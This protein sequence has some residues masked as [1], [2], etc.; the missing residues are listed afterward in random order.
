MFYF[1]I[2]VKKLGGKSVERIPIM[3]IREYEKNIETLQNFCDIISDQDDEHQVLMKNWVVVRLVS[4]VEYNLKSFLTHIIDELDISPN[5][6][7]LEDSIL[8]KLDVL[9][10]FQSTHYTKG[11]MIVA[12]LDYLNAGKIYAIMSRI[13]HVDYFKWYGEITENTENIFDLFNELYKLR[14]DVIHNLMDVEKSIDELKTT[15]EAFRLISYHLI[16]FTTINHIIFEKKW[17]DSEILQICK[18]YLPDLPNFE[19]FL[20]KFKKITKKYRTEYVP[21]KSYF[22]N[23]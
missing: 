9:E 11:K 21:K 19:S 23:N 6:I 3:D 20:Q 18:S 10:N 15:I 4:M 22:K 2:V 14:N 8:I 5:N 17:V 7:L 12:H 16:T 13:N 1:K